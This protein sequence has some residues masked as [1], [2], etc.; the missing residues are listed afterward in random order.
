MPSSCCAR[1]FLGLSIGYR[2]SGRLSRRAL[3]WLGGL[4]LALNATLPFSVRWFAGAMFAIH[5]DGTIPPAIFLLVL[6]GITPFY[7]VFLPRLI[8]EARRDEPG[9]RPLVRF[10]AAELAGACLGLALVILITPAR[11]GILLS[12]HLA[13]VV[14]LLVLYARPR[15]RAVFGLYAL[16]PLYAAAYPLLDRASLAWLY[17]QMQPLL[18]E[19]RDPRLRV[20]ALPASGHRSRRHPEPA[21]RH[22]PLS[23]RQPPLRLPQLST[24]TIFSSPSSR[25]SS[26]RRAP[27][28]PASSPE[29][30]STTPA[31]SPRRTRSLDVV[32]VDEAVVRLTR[33]HLQEPLR[34]LP[35]QL[36]TDHR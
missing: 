30:P 2:L 11:M 7:A 35:D 18:R 1:Y 24:G 13:G 22:L 8:D 19:R 32:E 16:L 15:R 14:T 27:D 36:A 9:S 6:C 3:L 20:L 34:R 28:A 5:F 25:T 26:P 31:T 23:Q 4:T 33:T 17:D 21:R 10:Y 12:L 29:V